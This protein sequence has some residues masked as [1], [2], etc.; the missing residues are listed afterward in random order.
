MNAFY[1]P[2]TAGLADTVLNE[3]DRSYSPGVYIIVRR[4]QD[5]KHVLFL[6][7]DKTMEKIY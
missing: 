7:S 4:V 6:A 3:T 2:S 1:V 5:N